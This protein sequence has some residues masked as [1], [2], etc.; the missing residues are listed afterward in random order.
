[1]HGGAVTDARL[2]GSDPNTDIAVLHVDVTGL[3][4]AVMGTADGLAPGDRAIAI[5]VADRGGWAT[6]VTTCVIRGM[7]RKL[8]RAR[9]ARSCTT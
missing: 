2:V 8:R 4:P 7:D 3:L 6:D 5:G 9:R 1:M